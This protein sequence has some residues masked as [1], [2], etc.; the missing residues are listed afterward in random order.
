MLPLL[1][2]IMTVINK[3]N[4]QKIIKILKNEG[5]IIFPTDTVFGI[6]CLFEKDTALKKLFKIKKR[7][8][9]K[10]IPLLVSN[11]EMIEGIIEGEIPSK[12]NKLIKL[13]SPGGLTYI[14]KAKK[15]YKKYANIDGTIAV[16]IPDNEFLLN[17]INKLK[18]PLFAT[19]ANISGNKE[20]ND[21]KKLKEVF[22][23]K[24]DAIVP[25]EP[26][27]NI[28]ST[29]ISF[30]TDLPYFIRIGA[31]PKKDIRSHI[32]TKT[33]VLFVCSGNTCRSP[34]AEEYAKKIANTKIFNFNSAGTLHIQDTPISENSAKII[35][36]FGGNPDKYST[37]LNSYLIRLNDLIL[38]MSYKHKEHIKRNYNIDYVFTLAEFAENNGKI[39]TNGKFDVTIKKKGFDIYDPVG[40]SLDFYKDTFSTIRS[41]LEKID[42]KGLNDQE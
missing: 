5:V 21:I 25:G 13:F 2:L 10:K 41:L 16:R 3:E 19:S 27:K 12:M 11:K 28:P 35:K 7:P 32:K 42:W 33:T 23:D 26:K 17:L 36:E 34:M 15:K 18:K 30:K 29:I 37:S 14:I 22:K 6:G 1:G 8:K 24:I 39:F 4:I 38:T 9:R 40:K 20:I 31:I